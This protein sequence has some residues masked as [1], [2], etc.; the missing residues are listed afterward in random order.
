M[1]CYEG[2]DHSAQCSDIKWPLVVIWVSDMNI[3]PGCCRIMD[4]DMV[5]GNPISPDI[6][7]AL[8]GST[9]YP[10]QFGP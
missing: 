9:V 1:R 3:D 10:D 6:T 2:Q 8:G 7:M 4:P 5:P